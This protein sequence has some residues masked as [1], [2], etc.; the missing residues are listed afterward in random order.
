VADFFRS[1]TR[2]ATMQVA[3]FFYKKVRDQVAD[4]LDLS[5][6]VEID[7]KVC[8]RVADFLLIQWVK[9]QHFIEWL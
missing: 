4:L 3:D 6:H 7:Q 1:A 9:I 2:F 8:D 5:R